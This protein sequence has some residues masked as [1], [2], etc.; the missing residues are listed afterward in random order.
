VRV[1]VARVDLDERKLDFEL[2]SSVQKPKGTAGKKTAAKASAKA[3]PDKPKETTG[4]PRK[5][6]RRS[7]KT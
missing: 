1:K 2:M 3:A 4:E 6:R 7:K 5:R